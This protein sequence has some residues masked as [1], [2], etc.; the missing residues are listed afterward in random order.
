VRASGWRVSCAAAP[1]AKST[2]SA[3]HVPMCSA[4]NR[5]VIMTS[6]PALP[7]Q[8]Y[9]RVSF[10]HTLGS[11]WK[12]SPPM[13]PIAAPHHGGAHISDGKPRAAAWVSALSRSIKTSAPLLHFRCAESH[14]AVA[15][16]GD[17]GCEVG[18][19]NRR[20]ANLRMRT[21]HEATIPDCVCVPSVP[22]DRTLR[23]MRGSF[24]RS[25]MER[26]F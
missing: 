4:A 3:S 8:R 20:Q 24:V 11:G 22:T 25:G 19:E 10:Q 23:A 17:S 6:P 21:C 9:I 1:V 7:R 26:V 18:G 2:D 5:F 16:K 14:D 12:C 15:N 13:M